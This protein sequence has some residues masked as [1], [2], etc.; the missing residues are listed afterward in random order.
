MSVRRVIAGVATVGLVIYAAVMIICSGVV[1][2]CILVGGLAHREQSF[3]AE[4][5]GA[6]LAASIVVRRGSAGTFGSNRAEG[7]V[8][9]D[10][11]LPVAG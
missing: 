5:A 3:R 2:W 8:G 6:G 7:P 9:V 1:G 11:A 4:G 10:P